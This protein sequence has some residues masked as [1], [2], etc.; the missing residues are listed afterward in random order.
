MLGIEV[1]PLTISGVSYCY[2][3]W[4]RTIPQLDVISWLSQQKIYPKVYWQDRDTLHFHAAVGNILCFSEA[5]HFESSVDEDVR[6]YGGIQFPSDKQETMWD[7][8]APCAFWLP[9]FEILQTQ[10]STQLI[11]HFIGSEPSEAVI[12]QLIWDIAPKPRSSPHLLKKQDSL[13][14]AQWKEQISYLHNTMKRGTVQKVVL[15]KKTELLFSHSPCVW[16]I[17]KRLKESA[18]AST[19]F[20]FQMTPHSAFAGATPEKLFHRINQHITIDALAATR[21]RGRTE[22]EDLLLEKE[23]RAH[24]KDKREFALVKD[25]IHS[26]AYAFSAQCTWCGQDSILKTAHVQHLYNRAHIVLKNLVADHELIAAFHPTPAVGGFPRREALKLISILESFQ[27]GWYAAPIGWISPRETN[28]A[29]ALR[30]C[31][32]QDSTLHLFAGAGIV[33]ESCAEKEWEEIDHK[34]RLIFDG[35]G[36][37]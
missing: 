11:A 33:P 10:E 34:M 19:V 21:K 12:A 8:F 24:P 36:L 1:R 37:V 22:D 2:D 26:T 20:A 15:A 9:A 14:F 5:P 32:I 30:S 16:E 17:I 23:L 29:I 18:Q 7:A 13:S 4:K 35:C 28:L 31:L 27:R 6:F 25:F 3:Q